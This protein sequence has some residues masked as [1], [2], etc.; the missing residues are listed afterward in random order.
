MD[1]SPLTG[2]VKEADRDEREFKALD[3]KFKKRLE[4]S[5]G[6][7]SSIISSISNSKIF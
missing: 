5:P 7:D 3:K 6:P 2:T 1:P 4:I